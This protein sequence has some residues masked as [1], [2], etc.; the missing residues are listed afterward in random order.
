MAKEISIKNNQWFDSLIGK[1]I[2]MVTVEG[3]TATI[4]I[5]DEE[6]AARLHGAQEGQKMRFDFFD[7]DQ[8]KFQLQK[9]EDLLSEL[10][11]Q[12]ASLKKEIAESEAPAKKKKETA[13]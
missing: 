13:V 5:T 12:I 9:M 10:P 7:N 4:T 11:A 2:V 3:E 6:H 1:D 8:R